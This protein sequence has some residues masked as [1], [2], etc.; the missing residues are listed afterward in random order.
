MISNYN[1]LNNVRSYKS[2][3]IIYCREE[4]ALLYCRM[5]TNVEEMVNLE[6]QNFATILV[7]NDSDKNQ[8]ILKVP[9]QSL[10]RNRIFKCSQTISPKMTSVAKPGSHHLSQPSN[11]C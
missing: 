2:I 7:I 11:Q 3:L 4:K 6:N 10:E 5:T 1:P 9:G 8:W